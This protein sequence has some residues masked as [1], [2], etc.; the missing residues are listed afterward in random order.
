MG[1][2]CPAPNH[3]VK[4]PAGTW[5]FIMRMTA[6]REESSSSQELWKATM[7]FEIEFLEH[8]VYRIF[9]N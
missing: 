4:P 2:L 6:P 1:A 5:W 7:V 8:P 9:M 3:V